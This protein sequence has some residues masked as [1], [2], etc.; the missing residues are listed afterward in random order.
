VVD[1]LSR[2][3]HPFDEL[4]SISSVLSQWIQQ[5]QDSYNKDPFA[6]ELITKLSLDATVVP[7]YILN[8]GL[9]RYKNKLQIGH[10]LALH[11][12]LITALHCSVWWS[13]WNSSHIHES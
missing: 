7:N 8:N 3:L 9:L 12:Q 13:L 10:D 5:V 2:R 4:C 1:A 6:Q 11:H